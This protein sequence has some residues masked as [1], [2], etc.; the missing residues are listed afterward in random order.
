M[1][2]RIALFLSLIGIVALLAACTAVPV[3]P[4]AQSGPQTYTLGIAQPF[5]GSL[6]EFGA[7]FGRGIELAVEQM[8]AQLEAAGAPVRFQT[9]QADTEQTPEGAARAVQTLVQTSGVQVI[10]GPLTTGEVLG[11]K[12][13]ADENQVVLV[14]PAS[15][16]PAG[17][18]PGDYIFR[19]MYPPDTYAGNAFAQIATARGYQN[20]VILAVDDP[21]G[22]GMIDIFTEQ[23]Q[24]AGGGEVSVTKFAP[25]PAD[26]SSEAAKVSAEIERLSAQGETAFFCICFL[27]D[28]QKLL[29]QAVTDEALGSVDWL[30]VENLV[31]PEILSDP[32]HAA[33]LAERGLTSVSF[34]DQAN[35]NTQPFL[36]AFQAK[37]GSE[38]GPFT[39]YAY[40]A[41]NVAML[42]MLAAG[43][44]GA[45]VQSMLPYIAT[46]YIGTSFQTHLDENG[47]QAV[48]FYGI[49]QLNPEGTEFVQIGTYDGATGQ[50]TLEE[51]P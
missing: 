38:P 12:Q 3:A 46:H 4:V 41:A 32:A 49:F 5:T 33:F 9:V 29:Q 45:A 28:A 27:G 20:V 15:S 22:N 44:D 17:G 34:A 43:N 31:N 18:I 42:T 21:F 24:A 7:D 8:N 26:L 51:A 23:F 19:V 36:D 48:V 25:E 2:R 50:V 47:D 16:G 30:G 39:N 37:Y 35:P 40:D 1:S 14:A 13:F 6:G 11:A 10:V